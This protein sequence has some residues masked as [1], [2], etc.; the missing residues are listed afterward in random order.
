MKTVQP[1]WLNYTAILQR[2]RTHAIRLSEIPVEH[3]VSL[4]IPTKRW[5]ESGY[6]FF[7]SPARRISGQPLLQSSPDRWCVFSAIGGAIIIYCLWNAHPF[8]SVT[9]FENCEMLST[10]RTIS[11]LKTTLNTIEELMNTLALNFFAGEPGDPQTRKA[12]AETMKDYFT[13]SLLN[14]YQALAPDFFQWLEKD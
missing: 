2:Q 4:P 9:N 13:T 11:Q 10:N 1:Q 7:A 14:Q 12:L 5:V 6:A 8:A 3:V